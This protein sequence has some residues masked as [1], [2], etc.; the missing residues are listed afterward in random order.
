MQLEEIVIQNLIDK[1]LSLSLAES[2]TGGLICSKLV[3]V[4]NASKVVKCSLVT[5]S[6]EAKKRILGVSKR[7]IN[8]YSPV[9]RKCAKMM[10]LGL[11]N[12]IKSDINLAITGYAGPLGEKIGTVYI[13]LLY[14]NRIKIKKFRI[15]GDRKEVINKASNIALSLINKAAKKI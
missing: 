1:K 3:S 11:S 15:R 12:K 10:V 8:Y 9:S 7:V 5:Y 2:I 13:A 6:N 4:P 14:K